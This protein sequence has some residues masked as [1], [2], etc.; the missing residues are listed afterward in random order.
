MDQIKAIA[1]AITAA[2]LVEVILQA[3]KNWWARKDSGDQ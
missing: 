1:D 3:F 2:I